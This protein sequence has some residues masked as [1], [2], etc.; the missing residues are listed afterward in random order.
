MVNDVIDSLKTLGLAVIG[1]IFLIVFIAI[2]W[3]V[4]FHTIISMMG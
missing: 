1:A 4:G 2:P 3:V